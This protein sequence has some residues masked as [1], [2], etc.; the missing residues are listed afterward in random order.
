[1]LR[2]VSYARHTRTGESPISERTGAMRTSQNSATAKFAEIVKGE[3]RSISVPRTRVNKAAASCIWATRVHQP[4]HQRGQEPPA[5]IYAQLR[6]RF[7]ALPIPMVKSLPSHGQRRT[8]MS[9]RS[10]A[11]SA[12]VRGSI[13]LGSTLRSGLPIGNTGEKISPQCETRG[14]LRQRATKRPLP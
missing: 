11:G 10:R 9:K 6:A 12:E 5:H 4:L 2:W 8:T 7:A 3:V 1:V 14:L 13:P